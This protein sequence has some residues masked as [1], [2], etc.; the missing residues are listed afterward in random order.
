MQCTYDIG[1]LGLSHQVLRLCSNQLLLQNHQSR[2]LRLLH[3][4]LMDLILDLLSVVPAWL[5]A[6]LGVPD[7]LQNRPGIVQV[8]RI[9]VLLLAQLADYHTNL[10][11]KLGDGIIAGLLAPI[12]E[13]C[14]N[15]ETLFAGGFVGTDEVVLGLDEAEEFLGQLGLAGSTQ[16]GEGETTARATL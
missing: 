16:A 8:V 2:V 3:L 11:G 10:V 13:L 6:L 14:A 15:R 5:D 1:K 9:D 12:G 4:E 7:R